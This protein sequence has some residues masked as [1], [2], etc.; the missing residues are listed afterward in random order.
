[1]SQ[2]GRGQRIKRTIVNDRPTKNAA[3][4]PCGGDLYISPRA[5][6]AKCSNGEMRCTTCRREARK[7][8]KGWTCG[9][10][11]KPVDADV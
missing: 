10:G 2:D 3:T 1:M 7:F 4:C 6:Y 8:Q 11:C 9:V 5:Q